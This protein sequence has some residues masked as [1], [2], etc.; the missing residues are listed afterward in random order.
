MLKFDS[1]EELL[2][3]MRNDVCI[4]AHRF[5]GVP[6]PDPIDPA[7]FLTE[8]DIL[9]SQVLSTTKLMCLKYKVFRPQ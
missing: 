8:Y 2:L 3:Q 7:Q 9:K 4:C 5:L 1:F 6:T